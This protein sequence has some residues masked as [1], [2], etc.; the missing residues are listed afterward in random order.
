MTNEEAIEFL[1]DIKEPNMFP[2][3]KEEYKEALDMAILALKKQIP[4]KSKM[5]EQVD[6][7]K[8]GTWD[9]FITIF[10]GTD[11]NA[12]IIRFI[13]TANGDDNDKFITLEDCRKMFEQEYGQEADCLSI[14]VWFDDWTHGEIYNY[15]NYGAK[16]YKTGETIGFA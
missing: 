10:S 3:T 4:K 1:I 2:V 16:W 7:N 6:G 15:G 9:A 5:Y 11:D 8:V 13:H 12:R 14:Y